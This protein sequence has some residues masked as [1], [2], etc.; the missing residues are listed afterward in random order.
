M[1]ATKASSKS[2]VRFFVVCLLLTFGVLGVELSCTRDR[3][4]L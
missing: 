2:Y 3:Q 4:V 1:K